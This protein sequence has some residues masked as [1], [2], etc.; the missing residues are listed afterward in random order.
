MHYRTRLAS[1]AHHLGLTLNVFLSLLATGSQVVITIVY[2]PSSKGIFV[3]DATQS[4]SS[5]PSFPAIFILAA[6]LG[7]KLYFTKLLSL[8]LPAVRP[9]T[10]RKHGC[11]QSVT[12]NPSKTFMKSH[13]RSVSSRFSAPRKQ[14]GDLSP[15]RS[16]MALLDWSSQIRRLLPMLFAWSQRTPLLAVQMR[17]TCVRSVAIS[18][19]THHR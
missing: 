18:P 12:R 5:T 19:H 7:K 15:F 2:V 16:S 9:P 11:K 14:R 1:G 17:R 8:E 3:P 10:K 4:V 13:R 6:V